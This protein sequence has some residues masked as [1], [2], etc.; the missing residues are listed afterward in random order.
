M[1]H[2]HSCQHFGFGLASWLF[3]RMRKKT[4]SP[5]LN[6][7]F[8]PIPGLWTLCTQQTNPSA[9]GFQQGARDIPQ[10][11]PAVVT[12]ETPPCEASQPTAERSRQGCWGSQNDGGSIHL[13]CF[14]SSLWKAT[15][16]HPWLQ[17]PQPLGT[18]QPRGCQQ[19]EGGWRNNFSSY[20]FL[21]VGEGRRTAE[22]VGICVSLITPE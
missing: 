3:L 4:W 5:T 17:H 7:C 21:Y 8:K 15:A 16:S 1:H 20:G 6:F 14:Q 12:A 2:T 9:R 10:G 22:G 19:T 13:R 18:K 11:S